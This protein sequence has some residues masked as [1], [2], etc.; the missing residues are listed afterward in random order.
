M[1]VQNVTPPR[2]NRCGLCRQVGHNRCNC[3][4][5]TVE[6]TRLREAFNTEQRQERRQVR[7]S[8]QQSRERQTDTEF[9]QSMYAEVV[10]IQERLAA[11][12]SSEPTSV[13]PR[14][15][16]TVRERKIQEIIFDNAQI[17]PDGLYK[18][19]MDALVIRG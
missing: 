6:A 2:R 16:P 17:I 15:G 3:P 11:L 5:T 13:V 14:S 12:V 18:E 4:H 19:L 10:D 8:L 9:R 7:Q 1:E